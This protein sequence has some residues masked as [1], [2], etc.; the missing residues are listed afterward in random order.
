MNIQDAAALLRA[1]RTSEDASPLLSLI[2]PGTVRVITLAPGD[3]REVVWEAIRSQDP[4][5]VIVLSSPNPAL[6]TT[7][8]FAELSRLR[9]ERAQ[10]ERP[11]VL[12]LP[13]KNEFLS[14]LAM[15]YHFDTYP[16]LREYAREQGK[17]LAQQSSV[18][19]SPGGGVFPPYTPS[20]ERSLPSMFA[21]PVKPIPPTSAP[22]PR[23]P[24]ADLRASP[25]PV[26]KKGVSSRALLLIL[27]AV[28]LMSLALG[29][30]L[31]VSHAGAPASSRHGPGGPAAIVG[32]LYFQSSG[33]V[34]QG[35]NQGMADEVE[36]TLSPI[37]SP[38]PGKDYFAWLLPDA[39]TEL[40]PVIPLGQLTLGGTGASLSYRGDAL[41]TNLL[42][43]TSR[44]LIT[45]EEAV[46]PP[47][48][49]SPDQ[50]AW[51]YVATIPQTRAPGAQ[52][53]L[54][55][56]LRHLL[57]ADPKLAGQHIQGGL[58]IWLRRNMQNI[59]EWSTSARD[60]WRSGG[61]SDIA[62]MRRQCIRILDYLDG[63]GYIGNDLPPGV[64]IL[65]DSR[66]ASVPMLEFDPAHQEP[67][68]YLYHVGLHIAGFLTSP[69]ATAFQRKE[70]A[71]ITQALNSVNTW[72]QQ[73]RD[74]ARRLAN[75][76]DAQLQ[77][78]AALSLLDDL[79]TNANS[80]Y[81]G[82]T[83]PATGRVQE[84]VD[85]ASQRIQ[86]LATLDI[87]AFSAKTAAFGG[88]P[89]VTRVP[90]N[91][92]GAPPV[93]GNC[94]L[95][96]PPRP[97]SAA[98]LA[99]PYQLIAT[100][101]AQGPCHEANA[102]Q[103]AFVQAAVFDPASGSIGIYEPLVVDQGSRP[104]LPP[105]VP[106]LPPGAVVALWFGFNGS[107]LTLADQGPGSSLAQGQCTGG[108]PGSPFGQFAYCN[109]VDFFRQARAAEAAGLLVPPPLG[110]ARDGEPCPSVR[111]FSVVDQDPSDNVTTT[112][113]ANASGQ[114]AQFSAA[115]VKTLQGARVLA[116]GSDNRL[117][118]VFLDGALGC[119][120]WMT[121]DLADPGRSVPALPFNELQ[122]A[123]QQKGLIALV[124]AGDPMV[125]VGGRQN[126]DKL[127]A[128]RAG[129]D[130]PIR[131]SLPSLRNYCTHL[132]SVAP[133][134]LQLDEPLTRG[135]PSPDPTTAT[136]LFTFLASRFVSTYGA[137][138]LG[139][140]HLLGIP[141][142]VKVQSNGQGVVV[143]AS[144]SAQVP[145][146]QT[147]TAP[148][149]PSAPLAALFT[150][151]SRRGTRRGRAPSPHA[152][153]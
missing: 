95:V 31:Y 116:N 143:A 98:G 114:T 29:S 4:P 135:Q 120:P 6:R 36:L 15:R 66:I 125:L 81:V 3:V 26:G 88:P 13:K 34:S 100:D 104:A 43:Q 12:V 30:F 55:D 149:V 74:D 62:F 79:A 127:N 92:L 45:E 39:N 129:V 50:G 8:D 145:P 80:A 96:V 69:G 72:L 37:A 73:V 75:M 111:D 61:G 126:L 112:Y 139:C 20:P 102:R 52:Y 14:K 150:V 2:A 152:A 134:R 151:A 19:E 54:L 115:N 142:P 17:S 131:T 119:A 10:V 85:W 24:L 28:L 38:A 76:S 136:S 63:T 40:S 32:H 132:L 93:N 47:I 67:P 57:V 59:F 89:A 91:A 33:Q 82:Q 83:D 48:N 44:L 121:P 77:Q 25:T 53:S 49:P 124:P 97:L 87:T 146:A 137:Q 123:A 144:I 106:H 56:H 46:A 128:Y 122:A 147:P 117:L 110:T 51:R 60:S 133:A 130:Q 18:Q 113:L 108:I 64:P 138:G 65:V 71:Q 153:A 109:A 1:E 42:A 141:D 9:R 105:L 107:T 101:A 35:S 21:S 16:S 140:E 148:T 41:H 7:A 99:T 11:F 118:S 78:D 86:S 90:S 84:G 103:S 5:L 94:T 58:D 68:G 23:S 22:P 70:A 27:L